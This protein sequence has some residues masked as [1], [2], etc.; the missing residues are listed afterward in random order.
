MDLLK[1]QNVQFKGIR[2]PRGIRCLMMLELCQKLSTAFA[3]KCPTFAT[4]LRWVV[5]RATSSCA[6]DVCNGCVAA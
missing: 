1:Y 4:T 5:G 3:T 6:M 2:E